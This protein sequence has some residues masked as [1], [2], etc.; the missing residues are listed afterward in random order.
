MTPRSEA[1]ANACSSV[2]RGALIYDGSGA[3]PWTADLA[4]DGE[5]ISRIG[6]PGM[7]V[8]ADE[9]IIAPDGAG[10]WHCSLH[11][12]AN[13]LDPAGAIYF[14]MDEADERRVMS[15]KLAMIGADGLP[16][17]AHPYPGLWGTF[18]RVIGRYARELELFPMATAIHKMSG[19]TAQVFRLKDRGVAARAGRLVGGR[20]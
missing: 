9:E 16:H 3:P 2:F 8:R 19:L 18:P 12:A 5:R 13:R 4:V 6:P 15:S 10:E 11:E 17:D 7:I 14:Q 1:T 20:I